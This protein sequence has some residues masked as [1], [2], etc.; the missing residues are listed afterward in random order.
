[1]TMILMGHATGFSMAG[2]LILIFSLL[3]GIGVMGLLKILTGEGEEG[4]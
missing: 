1:M 3:A 2:T 4:A